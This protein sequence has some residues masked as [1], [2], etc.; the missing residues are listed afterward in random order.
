[1]MV[2]LSSPVFSSCHPDFV[3]AYCDSI[4][5][6]NG[7]GWKVFRHPLATSKGSAQLNLVRSAITEHFLETECDV[8]IQVDADQWWK[9]TDMIALVDA[10]GQNRTDIAGAV[11]AL[12]EE[13]CQPNVRLPKSAT[14]KTEKTIR[15]FRLNKQLFVKVER[16][17]A[18]MLAV[19]RKCAQ[20]VTDAVGSAP[21]TPTRSGRTPI[22][23]NWGADF[24]D[25]ESEDYYFERIA[26]S[27]G[28]RVFALATAR[29]SHIGER[30][31]VAKLDEALIRAKIEIQS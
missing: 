31:Y 21:R 11:V 17:G 5:A 28:M 20:A 16:I 30:A 4:E 24:L 8:M 14:E 12:K 26:V 25:W 1:M 23:F 3:D 18:G 2:F 9:A 7:L 6:M 27:L 10:I 15:G 19:S 13:G 22:V 29:V